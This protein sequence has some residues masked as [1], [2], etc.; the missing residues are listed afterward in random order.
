MSAANKVTETRFSTTASRPPKSHGIVP[1]IH[2][3]DSQQH[4][5]DFTK[6]SNHT[7]KKLRSFPRKQYF[8]PH[9]DNSA[10]RKNASVSPS[11]L[12]SSPD[13][14]ESPTKLHPRL[15][16]KPVQVLHTEGNA[17]HK[18]VGFCPITDG[19]KSTDSSDENSGDSEVKNPLASSEKLPF[20]R[21]LHP[22][23]RPNIE[24]SANFR[25][26]SWIW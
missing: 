3:T 12:S 21:L 7:T 24:K 11:P 2:L 6:V 13:R 23:L 1:T 17:N 5:D 8:R 22:C 16:V 19:S 14:S 9:V 15:P 25:R 4:K 18:H 26:H 10:F 20:S